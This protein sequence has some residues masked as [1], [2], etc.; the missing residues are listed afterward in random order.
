[1]NLARLERRWP[2]VL[3][4]GLL[5]LGLAGFTGSSVPYGARKSLLFDARNDEVPQE[6][7][8]TSRGIRTDERSV[9]SPTVRSQQ[10]ASPAF[11]L[12]NLHQGLGQLQRNVTDSPVYL[13]TIGGVR[14][15]LSRKAPDSSAPFAAAR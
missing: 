14:R 9:D 6:T 2:L 15:L 7:L 5:L 11:P 4:A 13:G 3:A 10:L 1:V 8:G 12:V